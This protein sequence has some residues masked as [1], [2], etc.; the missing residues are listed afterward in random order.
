MHI[1]TD[2]TSY[3]TVAAGVTRFTWHTP[4]EHGDGLLVDMATASQWCDVADVLVW[5]APVDVAT[6]AARAARSQ[7]AFAVVAA[8]PPHWVVL[9][10]TH[11]VDPPLAVRAVRHRAL[12][13]AADWAAV[14]RVVV[15]TYRAIVAGH[16]PRR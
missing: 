4:R 14:L 11:D 12:V 13:R 7:A 8:R 16:D 3:S 15:E 1:S 9:T 10:F 2:S 5:S 6:A